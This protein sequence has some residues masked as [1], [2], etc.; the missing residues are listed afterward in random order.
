MKY[1]LQLLLLCFPVLA[2]SPPTGVHE[3]PWGSAPAAVQGRAIPRPTGWTPAPTVGMPSGLAITAFTSVDSIAGYKAST[4]YYFYKNQLFQATTK[5]NFDDLTT[6]D[7]NYNVYI[8]VDRYYQ[9]IRKRTLTFVADIYALL[10]AKYGRKQP[11]FIPLDPNYVLKATDKYL[12][13]E[14]WNLRYHPSEFYKRIT[15]TAYARWSYPKT[16]INFAVNISAFDK[17]FEYTLSHI[18]TELRRVIEKDINTQRG[19]GL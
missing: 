12:E 1:L 17:R 5:F 15:G 18:S 13:K 2:I 6:F 7:F 16:E 4:T 11:I 19:S 8:S 3:V 14:R 9:E 10:H